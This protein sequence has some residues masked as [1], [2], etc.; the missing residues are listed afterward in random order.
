MIAVSDHAKF[1]GLLHSLHS[2]LLS[3]HPIRAQV[4]AD[5]GVVDN[6]STGYGI[7][8]AGFKIHSALHTSARGLRGDIVWTMHTHTPEVV[9]I[10]SQKRGL[11][12]GFSNYSM[13]LGEVRARVVAVCRFLQGQPSPGILLTMVPCF[14]AA[15]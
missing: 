15:F 13:D 4:L 5:G 6:G 12:R 2:I 10:A 8:P 7:N 9:A 11:L 1:V 3:L 14:V